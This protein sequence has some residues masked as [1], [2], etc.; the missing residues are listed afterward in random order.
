[1]KFL[2]LIDQYFEEVICTALLFG[3]TFSIFF[4]IIFRV[5]GAPL[6]WTEELARYLFIWLIY[7]SCSFAV[8]LH[9]HITVDVLTLVVKRRGQLVLDLISDIVFFCF[10]IIIAYY[11]AQAVH[12]LMFVKPQVSA[13]LKISMWIPYA[14]VPVGSAMMAIRL[15]Q[16]ITLRIIDYRKGPEA[17]VPAEGGNS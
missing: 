2:L 8:R 13:G 5:M 3:M 11:G 4:Q 12:K 9:S 7:V 10:A 15:I 16:K 6:A 17:E 1:M 14:A